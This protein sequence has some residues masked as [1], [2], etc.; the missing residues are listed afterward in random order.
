MTKI[1]FF[2]IDLFVQAL[3]MKWLYSEQLDTGHFKKQVFTNFIIF[4]NGRI[5]DVRF[6]NLYSDKNK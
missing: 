2:C 3:V 1:I 4:E 5:L 6:C